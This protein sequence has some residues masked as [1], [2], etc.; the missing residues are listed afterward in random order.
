MRKYTIKLSNDDLLVGVLE[1]Q[2]EDINFD[3]KK[4]TTG[5]EGDVNRRFLF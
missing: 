5:R 3:T 2:E 1:I 4:T